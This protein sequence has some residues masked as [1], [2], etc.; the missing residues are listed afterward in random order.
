MKGNKTLTFHLL[1]L[2]VVAIWGGTLVNTK[3]LVHAGMSALEIFYA[4]YI[5]AYVAMLLF[6]HKRMLTDSWRD[7]LKMVVLGITGASLYFVSE[8]VAISMTNVN[9]VS[10]IVSASPIF[11]MIFSILFIKGTRLTSNFALGTLLAIAGVAMVIFNGQGELCFN[12]TGDLIAVLTSASFG[13]YSFLLKPI[14]EKYD[15]ATITRKVFGYGLLTALP[16]FLIWPWKFPVD[17][18]LHVDVLGNLLFLGLIAS[19][20]C[21]FLYSII[22]E[23]LGAM[24]AS[25]YNYLSPLFTVVIAAMF[26]SEPMTVMAYVGCA[27]IL[28]GVYVAN[29]TGKFFPRK[30]QVTEEQQ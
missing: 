2:F 13:L 12:P 17:H 1:A 30:Q 24:T 3:V 7:E 23:K 10:F 8:N 18:L 22:I 28:I 14:S 5:L 21:F 19:C 15:A 4:R 27:L 9:N 25:N 16:L 26:L 6:A 20:C 29:T 11:T